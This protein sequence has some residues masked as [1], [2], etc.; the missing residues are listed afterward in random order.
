M[1]V[2]VVFLPL[3]AVPLLVTQDII[4]DLQVGKRRRMPSITVIDRS[5]GIDQYRPWSLVNTGHGH[6][7]LNVPAETPLPAQSPNPS[8]DCPGYS[9]IR[10]P[11]PN[12]EDPLHH[13]TH[14]GHYACSCPCPCL[15]QSRD[16]VSVSLS[17]VPHAVDY[18]AVQASVEERLDL[19]RRVLRTNHNARHRTVYREKCL[20]WV[21][22]AGRAAGRTQTLKALVVK[23]IGT[24][25][26]FVC[27]HRHVLHA[28]ISSK[29]I[30]YGQY[31]CDREGSHDRARELF[32]DDEYTW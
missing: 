8:F 11:R 14:P 30:T 18:T 22:Y 27:Y 19:V 5:L 20:C 23:D 6:W 17:L 28:R 1:T 2:A 15:S 32:R 4:I 10:C 24:G 13:Q 3:V 29:S 31:V 21:R 16:W 25:K 7:S 9:L 26:A 12:Q